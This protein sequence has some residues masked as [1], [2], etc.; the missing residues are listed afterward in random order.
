MGHSSIFGQIFRIFAFRPV[1]HST[2]GGLTR[3]RSP[4][5][6]L[7][8]VFTKESPQ[9]GLSG[10]S[11]RT[12]TTPP[13]ILPAVFLFVEVISLGLPEVGNVMTGN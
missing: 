10:P 5:S 7:V 3:K 4:L 12:H 11:E 9:Q 1:F 2:P 8:S 6:C 13:K